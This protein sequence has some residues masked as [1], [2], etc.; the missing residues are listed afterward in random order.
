MNVERIRVEPATHRPKAVKP[1][2]EEEPFREFAE[3]LD[4][5]HRRTLAKIGQEDVDYITKLDAFSQTMHVVGRVLIH[6]S[7]EPVTFFAGVGALWVH[8]QLQ[9]TEVGHSALHGRGTG[10]RGARS[11]RRG[12]SAGRPRS[13]RSRG[14]TCTT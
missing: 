13:T 2:S 8:K 11:S 12:R 3:D 14:G 1:V 6:A 5:L 10:S 4:A 9:A 7:V